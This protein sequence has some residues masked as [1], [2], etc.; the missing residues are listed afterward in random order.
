[1]SR[2]DMRQKFM[3]LAVLLAVLA[4]PREVA[5]QQSGQ[6]PVEELILKYADVQGARDFVAKGGRMAVA[7][8]LLKA[9]PLASVAG[10]VDELAVLK[11]GNVSPDILDRFAGDL[12]ETLK[13][14]GY[15]GHQQTKNGLVDIYV[16]KTSSDTVEEL[17]IYNPESFSLN[18]LRGTFTVSELLKLS[19]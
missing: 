3:I 18:S 2:M 6:T 9:T 1:M 17:V 4:V 13:L 15:Y 14:Y 5:A 19:E 10:D 16:L 11:M 8:S 12:H 7:R